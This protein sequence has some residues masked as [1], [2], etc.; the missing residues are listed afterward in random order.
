MFSPVNRKHLRQA[1][2]TVGTQTQHL[3]ALPT[4]GLVSAEQMATSYLPVEGAGGSHEGG[5]TTVH[6]N[7]GTPWVL[8]T[9]TFCLY[10]FPFLTRS[11]NLAVPP[12]PRGEI[13]CDLF[14]SA[15][16]PHQA[17]FQL[18]DLVSVCCGIL[19]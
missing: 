1:A 2:K 9:W 8:H 7:P 15:L 6:L 14:A 18:T 13:S 11:L 5:G 19:V 16:W 10:Q 12:G 4:H 3:Q 17:P